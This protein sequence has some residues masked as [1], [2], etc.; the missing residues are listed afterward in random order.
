MKLRGASFPNFSFERAFGPNFPNALAYNPFWIRIYR[1]VAAQHYGPYGRLQNTS[2]K[3]ITQLI[4]YSVTVWAGPFSANSVTSLILN[5]PI[6][7]KF[8]RP[9]VES[10][11][12]TRE[13][14]R[15]SNGIVQP[16]QIT[17]NLFQY[18][19]WK[20]LEKTKGEIIEHRKRF[21][22]TT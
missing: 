13:S 8:S 20:W 18:F 14:K 21:D 22:Y 9:S 10:E 6:D 15:R 1:K 12:H 17:S 7:L 16:S 4:W 11:N 2:N 5:R 3:P 19:S